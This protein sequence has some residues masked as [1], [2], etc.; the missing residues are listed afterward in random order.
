MQL[1]I[2]LPTAATPSHVIPPDRFR[3]FV[4]RA[5]EYDF[6]GAWMI[7][8]LLAP[9]TYDT[10]Q[11]D[12]LTTLP[13][14]AGETESLPIGTSVLLLPLRNPVLMAKRAA[15][16]QHLSSR[17]LT[18]G[19]GTGYVEAEFEAV[20][21]PYEERS[22]RYLEGIELLKRLFTETDF[23]FDGEFYSVENFTLEPALDRPPRLYAGGGGT[24][25]DGDRRVLDSVRAR[26][27]HADGWIAPPRSREILR[28]DWEDF[29]E[30][31]RA[32]GTEPEFV[33]RVALQYIHL[34]PDNNKER[35]ER[36]QRT[37][38]RK[39]TGADRIEGSVAEHWLKGTVEDVRE[40]L[41]AYENDG[42][43][44]VI[45]QPATVD[46]AELDRQLRLYDQY[47]LPEFQ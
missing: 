40:R 8:H 22:D 31:L 23:S 19:L 42:F 32:T 2:G 24:E 11:F 45:L 38:Y 29:A 17:R 12:P 46:A 33:D 10:S 37:V 41:A 21:I 6:A 27:E 44:Q 16:L 47:L 35:A 30:Y 43:D 26:L 9:P 36:E 34:V 20:G 5:E 28:S 25:T 18:L 7:E 15:T 4:R 3:Q 13:L 1:G 39:M 14:V